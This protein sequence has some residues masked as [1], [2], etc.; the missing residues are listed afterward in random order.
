M[1]VDQIINFAPGFNFF[2][3]STAID[4]KFLI[5]LCFSNNMFIYVVKSVDRKLF[6]SF[7]W[8]FSS[9]ESIVV[10][11]LSLLTLVIYG[12]SFYSSTYLQIPFLFL[13][14]KTFKSPFVIL[15]DP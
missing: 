2:S 10:S 7:L 5:S 11:L 8:L 15:R 1:D 4:F 6:I 12:V 13:R 14:L 9:S 3:R